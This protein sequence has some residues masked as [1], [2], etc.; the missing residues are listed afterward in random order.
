MP[1]QKATA[2]PNRELT[3][4]RPARTTELHVDRVGAVRV[5]LDPYVSV[6]ALATDA[7]GRRRGAPL[8]WRRRLLAML[9]PLS[10]A[11]L[12][13]VTVPRYSVIPDCMSPLNPACEIAVGDQVERLHAI[14]SD[15]VLADIHTVF[16]P[17]PPP[18]WHDALRRPRAW[19]EAYAR[20]MGEAWRAIEPLWTQAHSLLEHETERVGAAV[21][22]GGLDLILDGLHPASRFSDSVLRIRDPEP[23]RFTLGGRPLVLVPMLSGKQALICNLERPDG[24]WI[25]YPLPRLGELFTPSDSPQTPGDDVLESVIGPVR[26]RILRATDRP[27]TMSDLARAAHVVPG[28]VTYHCERLAAAGLVR[29]DRRGRQIWVVRTTRGSDLIQLLTQPD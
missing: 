26:A 19:L 8:A 14:S 10:A 29:R 16:G 27:H 3:V 15:E 25:G 4:P 9:S 7:L 12:R 22:R 11:A 20:A 5:A 28:A 1:V 6:L 17:A 18:Q 13:P 2:G 24:V 21:M 23:G